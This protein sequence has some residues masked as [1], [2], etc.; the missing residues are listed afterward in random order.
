M[1]TAILDRAQVLSKAASD[2]ARISLTE[3]ARSSGWRKVLQSTGIIE[4]MDRTETAA[5]LVSREGMA[6]LLEI[7]DALEEQLEMADISALASARAE[8]TRW[9]S[10]EALADVAWDEFVARRDQLQAVVN[11]D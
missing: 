7:I 5:F 8:R 3:L 4:V 11:G 6:G 9:M 1:N 2:D 10:G